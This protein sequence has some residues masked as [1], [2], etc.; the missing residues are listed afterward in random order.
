MFNSIST[1]M[2]VGAPNNTQLRSQSVSPT[3][4]ERT[5]TTDRVHVAERLTRENQYE[6][7]AVA[8]A[9]RVVSV[10]QEARLVD[11][12]VVNG[13]AF[14]KKLETGLIKLHNE[15]VRIDTRNGDLKECLK[16]IAQTVADSFINIDPLCENDSFKDL[17]YS[18]VKAVYR[19][20]LSLRPEESEFK[21]NLENSFSLYDKAMQGRVDD[22]R[23]M[24]LSQ[25]FLVGYV[26]T[27]ITMCEFAQKV[28]NKYEAPRR[29]SDAEVSTILD[30]ATSIDYYYLSRDAA[31]KDGFFGDM[32]QALSRLLGS[33]EQETTGEV[34]STIIETAQELLRST[35]R[36]DFSSSSID[37]MSSFLADI[38]VMHH[39]SLSSESVAE[40]ERQV[41]IFQRGLERLLHRLHDE[42]VGRDDTYVGEVNDCLSNIVRTFS[43]SLNGV[44]PLVGNLQFTDSLFTYLDLVSK[45]VMSQPLKEEGFQEFVNESFSVF[46]DLTDESKTE[47]RY[48][49]FVV[50]FFSNQLKAYPF[51]QGVMEAYETLQGGKPVWAASDIMKLSVS[52]DNF[53][54]SED[55]SQKD[56]YYEQV[57]QLVSSIIEPGQEL[58][59]EAIPEHVSKVSLCLITD[60]SQQGFSIGRVKRLSAYLGQ[61]MSEAGV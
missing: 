60:K 61:A 17:M 33:N 10:E 42:I 32:C 24:T 59:I 8:T 36:R 7:V 38:L 51:T 23:K 57:L 9:V 21:S 46:D 28:L 48:K 22:D 5:P 39:Q 4:Q 41:D 12:E 18:Y 29:F 56:C 20:N 6:V 16:W 50:R 45:T 40:P 13:R 34:S 52:L 14:Q 49:A 27:Q 25:R 2:S 30:I 53:Y 3:Q 1:W 19:H 15:R 58:D 55:P 47:K 54:R 31:V 26:S 43:E 11:V 44:Q 35:S 37:E